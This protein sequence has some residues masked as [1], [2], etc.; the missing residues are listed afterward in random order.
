MVGL[1]GKMEVTT[2][3]IFFSIIKSFGLVP[4]PVSITTG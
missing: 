1:E 3:W 4:T 2:K